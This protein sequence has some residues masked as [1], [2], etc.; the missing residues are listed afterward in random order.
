[1]RNRPVNDVIDDSCSA[2]THRST[3]WAVEDDWLLFDAT[4]P[5]RASIPPSFCL[6]C[7][8][9]GSPI[10]FTHPVHKLA[11]SCETACGLL[12]FRRRIHS[13][14]HIRFLFPLVTHKQ[15]SHDVCILYVMLALKENVHA[16]C[17]VLLTTTRLQRECLA[18]SIG[19]LRP[20]TGF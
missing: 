2:S 9:R 5:D 6:R 8:L 18:A 12:G 4:P 10:V 14:A 3:E 7:W 1:M 17:T 20:P 15:P 13:E 11:A 16:S 19:C